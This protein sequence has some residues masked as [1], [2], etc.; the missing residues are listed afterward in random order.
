MVRNKVPREEEILRFQGKTVIVTGAGSGIG[1][2]VSLL[3]A[4]EGASIVASDLLESVYS[5]VEEIHLSGG[6]AIAV[7]GDVGSFESCQKMIETAEKSYGS[8]HAVVHAAA[9]SKNGN[10]MTMQKEDWLNILNVNLTSAF[11]L[12]KAA[13]PLLSRS[14]GAIVFIASQ[15]GLVGAKDSIAYTSAK[16]GIVNMARSMALDHAQNG[17]RVNSLCPGP[18]DTP[19]LQASF[20]RHPDPSEARSLSLSKIP[21]GRFGTPEE[22]AYAALFL[23]SDEASFITGA[24]LVADGGYTAR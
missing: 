1:R 2:A 6:R 24:T 12:S 4:L 3:F 14:G 8:L 22:I 20:N 9:I 19:F 10:V 16:G 11:Y 13:V 5:T 15:L 17:I 18:V 7:I 21:V 23:A